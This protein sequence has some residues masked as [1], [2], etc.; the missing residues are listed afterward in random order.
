MKTYKITTSHGTHYVC[1]A[2]KHAASLKFCGMRA[3]AAIALG[4]IKS[5]DC[6][7]TQ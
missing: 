2:S 1:A 3:S 6:E 4:Q 5:I 7:I